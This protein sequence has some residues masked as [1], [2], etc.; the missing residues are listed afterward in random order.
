M[1]LN[2]RSIGACAESSALSWEF[3]CSFEDVR[4]LQPQWDDSA[5]RLGG[6]IYMTFDWCR[7]WWQFYGERKALRLFVWRVNERIVGLLPIYIETVRLGL[8][9]LKV[10]RLVG[11][12]IPPKVFDPPLD[13]A[14]AETIFEQLFKRLLAE[15]GCD[16]VS[17]GPISERLNLAEPLQRAC[18]LRHDLTRNLESL[19]GVHSVFELPA[20]ME[21]YYG[22]LSKNERKNRRKYELRLLKKEYETRV[23][24]I[25]E[26]SKAESEFECFAQQHAAQWAAEGKTGHFGA[27]PKALEFNRALVRA[28]AALNRVRFVRIVANEEV[29]ANQYTYAFGDR[30]YW[31]LPARAI[32][33][34]WDR[35]SLGPTGLV[36]LIE[37]GIEEG[38]R[39]LEGGLAHY[40]YKIRLGARE[41]GAFTFRVRRCGAQVGLKLAIFI[42]FRKAME[43]GY[44]KLWYRRI[45]PRLPPAFWRPQWRLWLQFDF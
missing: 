7:I 41:Y 40:D 4:H 36:T 21:A 18:K 28:Q 33:P 26:L 6:S 37:R 12:N 1:L 16:L 11:A 44:H 8:I 39:Y 32:A 42:L 25:T 3:F 29:I 27:W 34:K 30:Y 22:A 2:D 24:V 31:E 5:A 35:F 23:E 13:P 17:L 15:D 19:R 38:K 14:F 43:F 9:R 20:N 45:A 10:A